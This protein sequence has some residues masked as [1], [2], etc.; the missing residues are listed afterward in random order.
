MGHRNICCDGC[1]R[2]D[3]RGRR[4]RC[5]RCVNYDLCG[6]CYDQRVE[7]EE[8]RFGHPMQLILDRD[9]PQ[10]LLLG[11]DFPELVH[12]VNCFTCP[13]CGQ[14]GYTAKRFIQHVCAQHRLAEAYVVCPMCVC[15]PDIELVAIRNL[16]RH[17]LLNHI[18]LA[19]Q[20]EPETPPL[21]R[22]FTRRRPQPQQQ[23]QQPVRPSRRYDLVLH[24]PTVPW[25]SDRQMPPNRGL[26]EETNSQESRAPKNIVVELPKK[27]PER[28]LLRK[29]I[30]Q[31]EQ[32]W[33]EME[34]TETERRHHGLFV[35]HLLISM[36]C[37][38]DLQLPEAETEAANCGSKREE[39][40]NQHGLSKVM[41]LMSL[42]WTRAWQATTKL[43][44]SEGEGKVPTTS[45]E[46]IDLED[47]RKKLVEP[48]KSAAEEAVD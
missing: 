7:T 34:K 24:V 12:L 19:N 35:E 20:F 4:F 31:Q 28:F 6:E 10:A 47:G 43:R 18:D 37:C 29:L 13:Y 11:G 33:Q 26:A 48:R 25:N 2:W 40:E 9:D 22:I 44:V 15:L 14:F 1:Q 32:R 36:L 23:G 8:H 3:F 42:P 21:R 16:S 27:Q 41:S 46:E 17:L 38:E 45:N 5:L 30:D 39:R